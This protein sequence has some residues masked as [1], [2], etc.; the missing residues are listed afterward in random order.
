MKAHC[1]QGLRTI[2]A[3]T[4]LIGVVWGPAQAQHGTPPGQRTASAPEIDA[5]ATELVASG[6]IV[7]EDGRVLSEKPAG[8]PISI[9]KPL[10]RDQVAESIRGL[11][12][13]GVYAE[14]GGVSTPVA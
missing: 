10:D 12:R 6:R 5:T 3:A 7:T 8:L 13:T 4:L 14:G 11:Y 2:V 9:G 1:G